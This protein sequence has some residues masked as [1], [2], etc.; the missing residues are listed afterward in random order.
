MRTP[1]FA[2]ALAALL[3]LLPAQA[4]PQFTNGLTIG[5]AELD[6]SGGT[7]VNDG[8]LGFFSDLYYD[9]H[10]NEWWGLSDRGPG[11]GTIS[12]NT[13]L[14]RFSLDVNPLTGEISNF[15]VQQTILFRDGAQAF[16]GLAP[17]PSN[18]L[19]NAFDPEGMVIL[20]GS[21]NIL[22][23]DE[24]G[25]SVIEFDRNGQLVRRYEVPAN[26]IPMVGSNVDYNATSSTL[27]A[28]RENNRGLEGL[29]VS[30]DGRYAFAMLQNGTITDGFQVNGSF[31]RSMYTRIIKYDT[32]TGNVLGQYAYQLDGN[33]PSPSQGR[34]ISA[35][36]ALDANR[37]MVLERNNRGVGVESNLSNPDKKIYIIDISMA[38]DVSA[39]AL[40]G[41]LPNG[42]VLASKSTPAL[43]DLVASSILNDASLAALGGRGAEKWEGLTVGPQLSDGSFLLLAGTDNDYSVTQNGTGTQFDVY[44]NPADGSRVQCDLGTQVH[45]TSISTTGAVSSNPGNVGDL[46]DSYELIPGV[47]IGFRA[48]V[49]D[50]GGYTPPVAPIPA[51]GPLPLAGAMAALGWSRRL[52]RRL[53]APRP[54]R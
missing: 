5:G 20:P 47:L 46:P 44:Y 24:Y 1:T 13:R 52:R 21:G 54:G 37:F 10:R 23:S 48:S 43:A 30:P 51:P 27:T 17:S 4:A 22:V 38:T 42:T 26:L 2:A 8:R 7:T 49:Q 35:I 36:V 33:G 25:P 12:Y 53:H 50:L 18:V 15:A 3:S 28:G 19:G 32:S 14:N 39:I 16:N 11:G 6:R 9:P 40:S 34:G 31:N 45:C 29:A 41:S